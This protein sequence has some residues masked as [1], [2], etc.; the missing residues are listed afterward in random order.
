MRP[1][2]GTKYEEIWAKILAYRLFVN[3]LNCLGSSEQK[4]KVGSQ[5]ECGLHFVPVSQE[6][7]TTAIFNQAR[8]R[9]QRRNGFPRLLSQKVKR[10]LC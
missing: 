8:G 3:Q 5:G 10:Y 1:N 6:C 2:R 7:R 4:P 9:C